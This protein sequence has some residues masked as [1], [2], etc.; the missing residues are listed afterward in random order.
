MNETGRVKMQSVA[1]FSGYRW[2][3]K[4]VDLSSEY[5]AGC[6]RKSGADDGRPCRQLQLAMSAQ[7]ASLDKGCYVNGCNGSKCIGYSPDSGSFPYGKF[8]I[9]IELEIIG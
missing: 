8:A 7:I 3:T 1:K 5:T 9:G 6:I 4:Q 2:L